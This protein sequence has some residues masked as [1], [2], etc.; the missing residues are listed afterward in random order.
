MSEINL[1]DTSHKVH[2]CLNK[3]RSCHNMYCNQ[4]S[5]NTLLS[6]MTT[7]TASSYICIT[8]EQRSLSKPMWIQGVT[9][10]SLWHT[11]SNMRNPIGMTDARSVSVLLNI[12]CSRSVSS[13]PKIAL[14]RSTIAAPTSVP[15]SFVPLHASWPTPA[16]PDN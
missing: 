4:D 16:L 8:T 1:Q 15:N 13:W 3:A 7:S 5:D 2:L 6:I 9:G 14:L 11:G 10:R 12:F